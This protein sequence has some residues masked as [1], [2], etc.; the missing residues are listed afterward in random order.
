MPKTKLQKL[1]L[2]SLFAVF[3]F[4][5]ILGPTQ[6]ARAVVPVWDVPNSPLQA[7]ISVQ[8]SALNLAWNTKNFGLNVASTFLVKALI[9]IL[10]DWVIQFIATGQFGRPLFSA[11]YLIDPSR[12][13]EY[14]AR[15]FLS[16]ITGINFCNYNLNVPRTLSIHVNLRL[17]MQCNVSNFR[18]LSNTYF[19][20]PAAMSLV[21]ELLFEDHDPYMELLL[22][23]QRKLEYEN[24]L[25][26]ARQKE[27]NDNNGFFCIKDPVDG[28]CTTP[29]GMVASYLGET[30]GSDY[31][32]CDA[33]K[34]FQEAIINCGLAALVDIVNAGTGKIINGFLG[35]A[36]PPP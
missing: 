18:A 21:D 2:V 27:L 36:F 20:S 14:A 24:K 6:Y 7:N 17:S 11:N 1:I 35:Q 30:I 31:R 5:S 4:V 16:Q 34:E 12:W 19:L 28:K 32:Q 23:K 8:T 26:R 15:M 3:L 9:N 22:A 13:A 25:V 29:G 33:A 10:R